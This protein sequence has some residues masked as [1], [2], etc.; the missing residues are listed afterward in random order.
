MP[1]LCMM[2]KGKRTV[3]PARGIFLSASRKKSC[4]FF[5]TP[6][7]SEWWT[8][9]LYQKAAEGYLFAFLLRGLSDFLKPFYS[10]FKS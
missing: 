8:A 1:R 6:K 3:F 9:P 10:F 7:L 5:L 2:P 4:K